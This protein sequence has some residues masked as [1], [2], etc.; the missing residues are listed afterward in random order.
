MLDAILKSIAAVDLDEIDIDPGTLGLSQLAATADSEAT[1]RAAVRAII[2]RMLQYNQHHHPHY[3]WSNYIHAMISTAAKTATLLSTNSQPF[4]HV[5]V[6]RFRKITA[7]EIP[8][9]SPGV[10][11]FMLLLLRV[12]FE[13]QCPGVGRV[14]IHD[15]HFGGFPSHNVKSNVCTFLLATAPL[16]CRGGVDPAIIW[17]ILRSMFLGHT[18][19]HIPAQCKI[20]NFTADEV[21]F[22]EIHAEG[23]ME[24]VAKGFNDSAI[25]LIYDSMFS[26]EDNVATLQQMCL[27]KGYILTPEVV[28]VG[29]HVDVLI[30]RIPK[31]ICIRVKIDGGTET[32]TT[33]PV[34]G[35]YN[36]L[37]VMT[38]AGSLFIRVTETVIHDI[39]HV[40]HNFLRSPC[41]SVTLTLDRP[42]L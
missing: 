9:D 10:D 1:F 27:S 2:L 29:T 14:R 21:V 17:S 25:S 4:E 18:I 5:S 39:H 30:Q 16:F 23:V 33:V 6:A 35:L 37:M 20:L 38:R 13:E 11:T 7:E 41:L 8:I 40:S 28:K 34:L 12:G 3:A 31:K 32:T 36:Q 24:D 19:V 42:I 22:R 15:D 26:P